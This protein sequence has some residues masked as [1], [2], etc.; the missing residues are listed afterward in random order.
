MLD[1]E[2]HLFLVDFG[3]A[4]ELHSE[5]D[6]AESFLSTPLY[7]APERFTGSGSINF[8]SDVYGVG[9]VFYQMLHPFRRVQLPFAGQHIQ[10][11]VPEFRADLPPDHLSFLL[12][13]LEKDPQRRL[14]GMSRH[15]MFRETNW[16]LVGERLTVK[17]FT[18][19]F[20]L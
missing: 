19:L 6:Y 14:A 7:L 18:I 9:C 15:R 20:L 11:D 13:T 10:E 3:L 4:K 1:R 12:S 16:T 17:L 2:G 5:E 8:K